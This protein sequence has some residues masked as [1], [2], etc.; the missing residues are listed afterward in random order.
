MVDKRVG[1]VEKISVNG[2]YMGRSPLPASTT[3]TRFGSYTGASSEGEVDIDYANLD[4]DKLMDTPEEELKREASHVVDV[5]LDDGETVTLEAVG[6]FS[7]ATFSLAYALTVHKA[8]G[9][10]WDTVFIVLHRDHA[11]S[12]Y[13]ELLYTAVT[14]ARKKVVLIAKDAVIEK[15]IKTQKIKGNTTEEKIAFFNSGVKLL[16]DFKCTK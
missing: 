14:R 7:P 12:L 1:Y 15:A 5:L 2:R 6:D 8:Q 10:E 16:T 9:C 4:I 3:L 13:R 11:V